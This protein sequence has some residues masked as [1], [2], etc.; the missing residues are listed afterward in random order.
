MLYGEYRAH[1]R[2]TNRESG[3]G[4]RLKTSGNSEQEAVP[5]SV[6]ILDFWGPYAKKGGEDET[7]LLRHSLYMI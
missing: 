2:Y 3:G 7:R 6:P 4:Y 5:S 1:S